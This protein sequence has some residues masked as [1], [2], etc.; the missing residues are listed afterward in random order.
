MTRLKTGLRQCLHVLVIGNLHDK[1]MRPLQ[2]VTYTACWLFCNVS[3]VQ[4][5]RERVSLHLFRG[6]GQAVA[7]WQRGGSP[8][9]CQAQGSDV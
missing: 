1:I 6:F 7:D 4:R 8:L 9:V 2:V 5:D 3:L